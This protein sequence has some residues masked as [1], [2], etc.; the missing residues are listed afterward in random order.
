MK[1]K[2]RIS[3]QPLLKRCRYLIDFHQ[4]AC[5][6]EYSFSIFPFSEDNLAWAQAVHDD[7]P[8]V[9]RF[10]E[11]RQFSAA[12]MCTDEYVLQQGGVGITIELGQK[13]YEQ[14]QINHALK[15]ALQAITQVEQGNIAT[16]DRAA[17]NIYT[18]AQTLHYPDDGVFQ[19]A[20]ELHNFKPLK[21]GEVLATFSNRQAVCAVDG[22]A[23]FPKYHLN[24][25]APPSEIWSCSKEN[26]LLRRK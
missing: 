26:T 23:L 16:S 20:P 19:L 6:S 2:E 10:D 25:S 22:Y 17:A 7:C 1:R 3:L 14:S 11:Q 13:G 5:R 8:I 24:K 21:K 15:V 4:T 18:V 12:G 9:T